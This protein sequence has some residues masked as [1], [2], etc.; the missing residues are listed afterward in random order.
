[1]YRFLLHST[2]IVGFCFFMG[3]NALWGQE[4]INDHLTPL[5]PFLG[6]TW[7]GTFVNSTP[8]K[9][10]EDVTHW[11]RALNGQAVRV[12]H[13]IN[14]GEYG[15]ET[16]IMWDAEQ[17]SLAYYYFTTAGFYT[18]GTFTFNGRK[19]SSRELVTGS[20][21]GI[22]EVRATGEILEDGRLHSKSQYLKNGEWIEGHEVYYE[23]TPDAKVVFK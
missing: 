8:E 10:V 21:Q 23:E 19:F 4:A 11:E 17:D 14:N 9:P 1:M 12:L 18:H 7:T 15:G 6:K 2:V 5:K 13:S 22:T 16:I 20:R 3:M